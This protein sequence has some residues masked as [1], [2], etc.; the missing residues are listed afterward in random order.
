MSDVPA[1]GDPPGFR[2]LAE[3]WRS[4]IKVEMARER[5]LGAFDISL[6]A[7]RIR[8]R[9][10]ALFSRSYG[11]TSVAR[12]EC[13]GRTEIRRRRRR[14]LRQKMSNKSTSKAKKPI[15]PPMIG[16]MGVPLEV[17][18]AVRSGVEVVRLPV[19]ALVVTY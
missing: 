7:F 14:L 12:R 8:D 6:D 1:L 2:S 5:E 18:D 10:E 4:G 17:A 11:V 19:L 15:T 3:R 16:A 13:S 9:R